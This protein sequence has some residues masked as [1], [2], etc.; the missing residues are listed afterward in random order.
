MPRATTTSDAF[1]AIAEPQRRAIVQL[2]ASGERSVGDIARMLQMEQP[3]TS[4][5]LAVLKEVELVEVR[6]Q[7][8]QRLYKLH[9][10]ALQP[11]HDWVSSFEHLWNERLDRLEQYLEEVQRKGEN[12]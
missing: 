1:N 8:K 12:P 5:H 10:Q 11:I 6:S 2:L 3:Q 4:K 9:S 7:G